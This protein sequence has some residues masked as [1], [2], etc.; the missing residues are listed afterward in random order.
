[1]ILEKDSTAILVYPPNR[2]FK[3]NSLLQTALS[4]LSSSNEKSVAQIPNI[5]NSLQS[6]KLQSTSNF[7]LTANI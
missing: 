5:T 7:L 2:K 1:M 6:L 3:C 4:Y